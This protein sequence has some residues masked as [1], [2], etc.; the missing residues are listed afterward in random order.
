MTDSKPIRV[1]VVDDS[2]FMRKVLHSMI[3]ADPEMEVVGEARDGHEA[4]TQTAAL[5]PDVITMD[6]DMPRMDGLEATEAIMSAHPA[7]IVIVSTEARQGSGATDRALEFGA[8]DFWT[9]PCS[10][11]DLDM[12]GVRAD[13]A[14]KLKAAVKAG[15]GAGFVTA[16]NLRSGGQLL[17]C[18]SGAPA[19]DRAPAATVPRVPPPARTSTSRG[20][21]NGNGQAKYAA[22]ES[23]SPA[24]GVPKLLLIEGN[25]FF[26]ARLGDALQREGYEVVHSTRAADALTL[27]KWNMPTAVVCATGQRAR[28]ALDIPRLLRADSKTANIP[29]I[30]LGDGSGHALM[31]VFRAGCDDYVDRRLEPEHIATHI[32]NFLRWQEEAQ[33]LGSGVHYLSGNLAHLD[34][35]AVVQMLGHSRQ[36][37]ALHIHADG[38]DAVMFLD[39]GEVWHAE[40]G[41]LVGDHAVMH[42]VKTCNW[43]DQGVYKFIPDATAN[44]RTVH[45]SATELML[46][47]LRHVDEQG[48]G[49]PEGPP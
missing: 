35:P 45:R 42:I 31:D 25:V 5:R 17:Q 1:L 40:S 47:A 4:V 18:F 43:L 10:G 7:P 23:A 8:V 34:L 26:A 21:G 15:V 6:L 36:T 19:G 3:T 2:A 33:L 39:K 44:T 24:A 30:A 37:G 46:E 32:R 38:M 9:K 14:S 48:R 13:L 27:L 28:E 12:E 22:G 16:G 41:D 20:N 11:H 49:T 29:V